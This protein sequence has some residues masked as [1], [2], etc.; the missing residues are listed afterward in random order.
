MIK[1]KASARA[2]QAVDM[3]LAGSAYSDI[4]KALG[5]ADESGAWRAVDRLLSRQK[6]ESADAIRGI[7]VNRLDK[8]IAAIWPR[9]LAGDGKMIDVVLRI[10]ER[11]ARYLGLDAPARIDLVADLRRIAEAEGLDPDEA[12]AVAQQIVKAGVGG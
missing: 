10:M 7:E 8:L 11:R 2:I 4:A 1:V 5:Y 6:R 9:A 12:V 3:R